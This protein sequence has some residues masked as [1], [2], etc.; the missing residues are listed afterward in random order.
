MIAPPRP[1]ALH[2]LETRP[3]APRAIAFSRRRQRPPPV[4]FALPDLLPK[5]AWPRPLA[6]KQRHVDRRDV[7]CPGLNAFDAGVVGT[8][9]KSFVMLWVNVV[10]CK[11][12]PPDLAYRPELGRRS[13]RPALQGP[14]LVDDR[15]QPDLFLAGNATRR[16]RI[17]R[18]NSLRTLRVLGY[19]ICHF[20]CLFHFL[21]SPISSFP[22]GIRREGSRS[23]RADSG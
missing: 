7:P 18:R 1:F 4:Y 14:R 20:A 6:D 15:K 12:F 11:L 9:E 10:P 13:K 16:V 8:L 23:F 21:P 2:T 3:E 22:P 17:W 19:L 5:A